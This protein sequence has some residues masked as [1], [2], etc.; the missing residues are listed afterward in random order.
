MPKVKNYRTR[1][2]GQRVLDVMAYHQSRM[3]L[4]HKEFA[5]LIAIP[6]T[7]LLR[8]E[9][10]PETF[11]LGELVKIAKACDVQ[12]SEIVSGTIKFEKAG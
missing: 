3:F 11:T 2:P 12:L 4:S 5:V 9:K 8:R 1:S 6:Y 7:T 10:A